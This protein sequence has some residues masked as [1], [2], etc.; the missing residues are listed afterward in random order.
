MTS[1]REVSPGGRAYAARF[2]A[3]AS[4]GAAVHGEADLVETLLGPGARVLDAGCG[5]GRV[6]IRLRHRG[7]RVHGV[8][9]DP[10]ML[11]V[12]READPDI[13][14]YEQ[15]LEALT[16]PGPYD[17]VVL[18]GNVVPLLSDPAAGIR[19][20]VRALAPPGFLLAGFGLDRA[21]LPL[22]PTVDLAGYDAM[23]ADAGLTLRDRWATWQREPYAGGPY[24]VSL[25]VGG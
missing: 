17:L 24:A 23:C 8:D 3:L 16:L 14:W 5:T 18:A 4:G 11:A 13:S 7:F 19:Q 20:I 25:H 2:A 15:G 1:W 10:D 22:E 12:A 6:A 21:H 9:T